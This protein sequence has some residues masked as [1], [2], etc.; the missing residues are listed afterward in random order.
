MGGRGQIRNDLSN[1]KQP[2]EGAC[3]HTGLCRVAHLHATCRNREGTH[4]FTRHEQFSIQRKHTSTHSK[5]DFRE[6]LIREAAGAT[7]L[8]SALPRLYAATCCIEE[9]VFSIPCRHE[10]FTS[11]CHECVWIVSKAH[12]LQVLEHALPRDVSS[13]KMCACVSACASVCKCMYACECV[14]VN[15]VMECVHVYFSSLKTGKHSW[16]RVGVSLDHACYWGA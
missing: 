8:A 2:P 9:H 10:I 13:G 15:A 12:W 4:I 14:R 1:S 7:I 16:V 3:Q 6:R 11:K 5:A